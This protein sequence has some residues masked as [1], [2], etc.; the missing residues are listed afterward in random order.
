VNVGVSAR[1]VLTIEAP[2]QFIQALL[3]ARLQLELQ[4]SSPGKVS[5]RRD[6]QL[7]RRAIEEDDP[8]ETSLPSRPLHRLAR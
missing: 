1:N 4:R 6:L 5:D 7:L 8:L 2:P 3:T